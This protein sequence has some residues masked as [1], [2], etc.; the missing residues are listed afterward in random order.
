MKLF[1]ALLLVVLVGGFVGC[2]PGED[3]CRDYCTDLAEYQPDRH[4]SAT[5]C[6]GSD[7][8]CVDFLIDKCVNR[9]L[10]TGGELKS[11]CVEIEWSSCAPALCCTGWYY[12]D[13]SYED[14]CM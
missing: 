10:E 6:D 13:D 14:I 9:C 5:G 1:V 3:E 4:C 8:A 2:G 12:S 7:P 11:T